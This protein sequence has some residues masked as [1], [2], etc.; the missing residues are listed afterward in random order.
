MH[1]TLCQ[2]RA[3][4]FQEI[5]AIDRSGLTADGLN[6]PHG[7]TGLETVGRTGVGIPVPPLSTIS[8]RLGRTVGDSRGLTGTTS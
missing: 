3:A 7:D 1:G 5:G 4:L 8:P 6:G 2:V